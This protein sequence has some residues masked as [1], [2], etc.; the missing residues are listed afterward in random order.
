MNSFLI[1]LSTVLLFVIFCLSMVQG[2]NLRRELTTAPTD[3][4][5]IKTMIK[6]VNEERKKVA[7]Y[8]YNAGGNYKHFWTQGFA[9]S[10]T[11]RCS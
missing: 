5:W 8:G 2:Q 9:A 3:V 4:A 1:K 11:E 7:G 6:L 10:V